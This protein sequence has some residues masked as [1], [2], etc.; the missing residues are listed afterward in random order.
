MSYSLEAGNNMWLFKRKTP[1]KLP[2]EKEIEEVR[3]ETHQ[4]IHEAAQSFDKLNR[5]LEERGDTAYNVFVATG[6]PR[7]NTKG[8]KK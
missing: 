5:L 4:K 8:K 2:H 3:K 6:G 1:S 7:R